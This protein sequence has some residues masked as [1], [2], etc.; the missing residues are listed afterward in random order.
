MSSSPDEVEEEPDPI[1][2]DVAEIRQLDALTGHPLAE[3]I[4]L[5]A[6]PVCGPYDA[7]MSCK[8]KVHR[9]HQ[10]KIKDSLSP[11]QVASRNIKER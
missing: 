4:I 7:L 8:Y 2:S 10:S 3:D 5:Y 9:F 11:D 1:S 6:L